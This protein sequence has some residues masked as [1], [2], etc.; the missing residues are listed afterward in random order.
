MSTRSSGHGAATR[1]LTPEEERAWRAYRRMVT[2]VQV[3]TAQALAIGLS[4][5]AGPNPARGCLIIFETLAGR[6]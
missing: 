1:W 5:H 6:T 4:P 2:A 3:R